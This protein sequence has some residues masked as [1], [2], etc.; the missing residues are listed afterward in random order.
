MCHTTIANRMPTPRRSEPRAEANHLLRRLPRAEYARLIPHLEPVML[1]VR[2]VVYEPHAPITHVYF[3]QNGMLSLILVLADGGTVEVGMVGREGVAG[4]PAVLGVEAMPTRCIVQLPMR[5]QAMRVP[6]LRRHARTAG[7]LHEILRR[8]TQTLIDQVA[9][10]AACNRRHT[11][12]RRC[13]R[14]LLMSHDRAEADA[15]PL[16][17]EFL[18]Y[19][20]G[21]HRPAVASAL[22][23]LRRAG[24]IASTRGEVRITDRA[25]LERAAC[26]CYGAIRDRMAAVLA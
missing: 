12:E 17:Q 21:V 26:E 2:H 5:A 8:Y 14:W 16:T 10:G 19:M 22:G 20:L 11:L 25:G 23:G 24:L 7:V 13:A 3:P 4:V 6:V 1:P 18:A 9:Q 15:F